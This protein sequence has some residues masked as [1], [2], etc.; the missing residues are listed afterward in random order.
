MNLF[1]LI[2]FVVVVFVEDNVINN[3]E[4][5]SLCLD[6]PTLQCMQVKNKSIP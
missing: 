6:L 4:L 3:L 5:L 1:K 2:F